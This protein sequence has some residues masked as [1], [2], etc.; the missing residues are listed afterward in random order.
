MFPAGSCF[1]VEQV[2][3]AKVCSQIPL[4]SSSCSLHNSLK[5][6]ERVWHQSMRR[7][8]KSHHHCQTQDDFPKIPKVL[9]KQ[10]SMFS[11]ECSVSNL[12]NYTFNLVQLHHSPLLRWTVCTPACTAGE[13]HLKKNSNFLPTI[14]HSPDAQQCDLWLYITN[15]LTKVVMHNKLEVDW[16]IKHACRQILPVTFQLS[17]CGR[18]FWN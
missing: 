5:V 18:L 13:Q 17:V 1:F 4:F 8:N 10:H 12:Y 6:S 9:Q 14:N 11:F 15:N 2:V 16:L 3:I 7:K